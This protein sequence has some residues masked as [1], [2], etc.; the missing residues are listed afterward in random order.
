[1]AAHLRRG[2]WVLLAATALLGS[3]CNMLALP[4]F[5]FSPE[6][7]FEADLK[8]IA[9][10]D[11]KKEVKVVIL[12]DNLHF[13]PELVGADQE[14][15]L[16]TGEH[17][18]RLFEYNKENVKVVSHRKVQKYMDEHPNWKEFDLTRVGEDLGADYVV[19]LDIEH[20]S[21]FE[22]GSTM[23]Y[24]GEIKLMVALVDVKS[25]DEAP[26]QK[27][28]RFTFPSESAGGMI[29]VDTSSMD[30]SQFRREFLKHAGQRLAWCFTSHPTQESYH[31]KCSSP[32]DGGR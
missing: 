19:N 10:E 9:P 24:R 25:P 4:F 27:E 1:M 23:L 31:C 3:G 21:L 11:K 12:A 14:L 20:L 30:P 13:R 8:K 2:C 22:K 26:A 6:P 29:P 5:L 18:K 28:Y 17:L 32:G 16:A 7:R 15:C